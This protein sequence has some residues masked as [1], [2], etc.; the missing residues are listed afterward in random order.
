MYAIR[1]ANYKKLYEAYGQEG[2]RKLSQ[3]LSAKGLRQIYG[4]TSM[5]GLK[6]IGQIIELEKKGK[7]KN[8]DD[9]IEFLNSGNRKDRGIRDVVGELDITNGVGTSLGENEIINM[10]G[11]NQALTNAQGEKSTSFDLA[12]EDNQTGELLRNIEVHR[13]RGAATAGNH[14]DFSYGINHAI[15]KA[16]FKVKDT[17]GNTVID[18]VIKR[19]KRIPNPEVKGKVEAAININIPEAGTVIKDKY[20]GESG[21]YGTGFGQGGGDLY[22]DI[23]DQQLANTKKNPYPEKYLDRVHIIDRKGNLRAVI[24]KSGNAK[25]GYNWTITRYR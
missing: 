25:T 18:P 8:F 15:E 7:V 13:P 17:Q 6:K 12:I 10:G 14:S 11:D 2:I 1:D 20:F 9:W 23:I 24:E 4:A 16:T 5:D 22:Q 21:T 3:K 19:A